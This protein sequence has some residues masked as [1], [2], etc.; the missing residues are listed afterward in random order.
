MFMFTIQS[1]NARQ[2]L[3]SRANPT[4]EVIIEDTKGNESVASVPSGASVGQHEA[5]ELRDG[6]KDFFGK[7]VQKAIKNI[8][9]KIWKTLKGK[10]FNDQREFD[11]HL[12]ELDGTDNKK[13]LGANATLP[14]SLAV[15]RL[16]AGYMEIPL[17]S[18]LNNMFKQ[19]LKQSDGLVDSTTDFSI[20]TPLFNLINGGL[21]TNNN[22]ST[23]EFMVVPQG[24]D[25]FAKQLQAGVEIYH[26]LKSILKNKGFS[27]SVG[28]EGGFAPDLGSDWQ[29]LDLLVEAS[30]KTGYKAGDQV[31]LALDVAISQYVEGTNKYQFKH[32]GP[33]GD[34]TLT[35]S[36][37]IIQNYVDMAKKY[38]LLLIEDGLGE[39]DWKSWPELTSSL[40]MSNVLSIGDDLLV[41]NPARLQKAV[42]DQA[43]TGMIIKPNQVGTI[44]EVITTATMCETNGIVKIVSHRSGDTCDSFIS[45]LAVGI[46]AQ[47]MKSGAPARGERVA[48]YNRLLRI[49]EEIKGN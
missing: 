11:N 36:S 46:Q 30:N 49:E 35:T 1:V 13:V 20:P 39:E 10:K 44:S 41:T 33:K 14:L 4:V 19:Q 2:I 17:Y 6:G 22:L 37:Q 31:S 29:A 34:K 26:T 38:P 9:D 28:D 32:Q 15:A 8:E 24:M 5:I 21:H 7:G 27:S 48:K 25:S 42:T 43:V 16:E 3:D 45:D 18:F 40:M 12:L 23:Q 47:Y